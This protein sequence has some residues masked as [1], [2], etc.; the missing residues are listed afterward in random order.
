M[1][2][3]TLW[4][5]GLLSTTR[6]ENRGEGFGQTAWRWK[7]FRLLTFYHMISWPTL[8]HACRLWAVETGSGMA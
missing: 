3:V 4:G 7:V 8:N 6:V 1:T 2:L 5:G